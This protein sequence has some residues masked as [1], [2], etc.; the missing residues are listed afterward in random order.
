[1]ARVRTLTLVGIAAAVTLL[2][3]APAMATIIERGT[4]TSEPY[5]FSHD[6]CGYDVD[7]GRTRGSTTSAG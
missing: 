5:A 7:V 2:G 6:D 1:M 4:Y 3:G